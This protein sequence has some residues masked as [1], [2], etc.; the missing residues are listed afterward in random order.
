M[1][2]YLVPLSITVLAFV[3]PV[4]WLTELGRYPYAVP[5]LVS[6][7]LAAACLSLSAWLA[8]AVLT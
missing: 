6:A 7:W 3:L 8:W 4:Y 5:V 2:W 1:T